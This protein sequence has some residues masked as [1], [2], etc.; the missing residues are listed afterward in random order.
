M[1]TREPSSLLVTKAND[2]ISASYRLT[3]QEQR[4]LL[5]AIAQVDPRKP[6]PSKITVTAASFAEIYGVPIRFAYTNLK[7][8]ADSLYERDI[9]TFD[10]KN[11][12]RIRWVYKATYAE[13][14]GRV[15]LN[16]TVD[17]IPY[18][19]MLNSKLTSYDLRR[20]ANLN[21]MHS[22]RLFELLMQFKST[23]LLIIEVEKLRI[24]LDLGDSYKRF[25]NLRQRVITPSINEIMAKSGITI[26]YQTITEGK[27]VKSLMFRFQEAA[28]L[29]L[30]L[31]DGLEVIPEKQVVIINE[32]SL[33]T[34]S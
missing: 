12:T 6:M 11:R 13:G 21:S 25:N 20:V 34:D 17:V 31:G 28:Q 8:A 10:G 1:T 16:F 29:R 5:A 14:E 24:L 19:S 26:T 15:T 7:E 2:L 27:T 4:L 18:L 9:Q 23:G 22:F 33:E 32:L 3:L 30:S